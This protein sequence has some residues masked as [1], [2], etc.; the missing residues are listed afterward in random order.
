MK[1]LS[2]SGKVMR[3]INARVGRKVSKAVHP[4]P[5]PLLKRKNHRKPK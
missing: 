1:K 5:M 3:K 2:I 4:Y